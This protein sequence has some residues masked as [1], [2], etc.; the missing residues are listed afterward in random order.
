MDPPPPPRKLR[1]K[2]WIMYPLCLIPPLA[3]AI[4]GETEWKFWMAFL[5]TFC[6]YIPGVIWA[7][8]IIYKP[9][10]IP[11]PDGRVDLEDLRNVTPTPQHEI[12]PYTYGLPSLP[13]TPPEP[14]DPVQDDLDD[15][16][17]GYEVPATTYSPTIL[18][19][20]ASPGGTTSASGPQG[21]PPPINL[22]PTE[23]PPAT[24]PF[25]TPRIRSGQLPPLT[26]PQVTVPSTTNSSTSA[27]PTAAHKGKGRA[28]NSPVM[29]PEDRSIS[30]TPTEMY[31]PPI[32]QAT[33][34]ASPPQTT[35]QAHIRS[36]ATPATQQPS[37]P[38]RNFTYSSDFDRKLATDFPGVHP[39]EPHPQDVSSD[40]SEQDSRPSSGIKRTAAFKPIV[41]PQEPKPEPPPK[42]EGPGPKGPR[43]TKHKPRPGEL[44]LVDA[45]EDDSSEDLAP[46]NRPFAKAPGHKPKTPEPASS[47]P[48]SGQPPTTPPLSAQMPSTLTPSPP[49]RSLNELP[50]TPP[51]PSFAGLEPLTPPSPQFTDPMP[52]TP[53]STRS[54]PLPPIPTHRKED[55]KGSPPAL[56]QEIPSEVSSEVSS[57]VSTPSG[58]ETPA[59]ADSLLHSTENLMATANQVQPAKTWARVPVTEPSG[60]PFG[61]TDAD[62]PPLSIQPTKPSLMQS[63]ATQGTDLSESGP[64]AT[65]PVGSPRRP[66]STSSDRSVSSRDSASSQCSNTSVES[67]W[68]ASSAGERA[69]DM[70]SEDM[71]QVLERLTQTRDKRVRHTRGEQLAREAEDEHEGRRRPKQGRDEEEPASS[72]SDPEDED[73]T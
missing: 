63:T 25:P 34:G 36:S 17:P 1:N 41:K 22:P 45:L 58:V 65:Q 26:G 13:P 62:W 31:N 28:V 69:I 27:V 7:A 56:A 52:A 9:P 70:H 47:V 24:I 40:V 14:V 53:R 44:R 57:Q 49:R 39:Y 55:L 38:R 12:T 42:H 37:G 2:L 61:N 3:V 5:L 10:I 30:T 51:P 15:S 64:T 8:R 32:P 48:N 67:H 72:S 66:S 4:E 59:T 19:T 6:G 54:T 43:D 23:I 33:S 20:T 60:L 35:S 21:T 29:A 11:N 73:D 46:P 18:A 50:L 71:D 16:T 68:S